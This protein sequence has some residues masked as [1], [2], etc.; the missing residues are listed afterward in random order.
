MDS[1]WAASLPV[2]QWIPTQASASLPSWI[3]GWYLFLIVMVVPIVL[4]LCVVPA[5]PPFDSEPLRDYSLALH[6]LHPY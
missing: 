2:A 6:T 5:V 1:L 4:S 3:L